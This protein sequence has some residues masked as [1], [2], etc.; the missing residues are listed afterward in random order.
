MI[1]DFELH[2]QIGGARVDR[3]IRST[4]WWRRRSL[5]FAAFC[6]VLVGLA[7]YNVLALVR[8]SRLDARFTP[9]QVVSLEEPAHPSSDGTLTTHASM[10]S[11]RVAIAPVVSPEKSL[12]KYREF[13][14]YLARSLDR[15]PVFLQGN[16][17]SEVNELLRFR[18]CDVA[19]VCTYPFVRAEKE[20]GMELLATPVIQGATTYHSLILVS[21]S[22]RASSLF[23]LRGKRFASADLFSNSGWLFPAT[24]LKNQGEAENKFFGEH[25]ITGSHD[26]AILAVVSGYVDGA[27]VHSLVHQ[28]MVD[29]DPD[30]AQRTRTILKSPPFG[31]PPLVTH[32]KMDPTLKQQL[33]STLLGMHADSEGQ[34]ILTSLGIDRFEVPNSELYDNVRSAA[35]QIES[36]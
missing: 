17:Y 33:L 23:D 36:S 16:S 1:D 20:F 2:R 28:Q 13:V 12:R 26:R 5:P 6:I 22:S 9:Q 27:A 8:H 11:L 21:R 10:P 30:L 7:V 29:E 31:M 32:P 24:W 19:L 15:S 14:G 25:V 3:R 35:E 34:L 18:G 4:V